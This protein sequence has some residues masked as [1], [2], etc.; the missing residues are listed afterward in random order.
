MTY[1]EYLKSWQER[2][3][4]SAWGEYGFWSGGVYHPVPAHRLSE[5]EFTQHVNGLE[6][7]SARFADARA[8]TDLAGMDTALIDSLPHELALL[9]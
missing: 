2:F 1:Q 7:A 4:E 5:T 3:G 6:A 9:I 8:K